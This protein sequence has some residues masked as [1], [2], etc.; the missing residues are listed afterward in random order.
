VFCTRCA[1]FN[2]PDTARCAGCGARL[3]WPTAARHHRR[4]S[5]PQSWFLLL[6]FALALAVI[7]L[8]GLRTWEARQ[9]Q[10][11][12]Y[13]RAIA[14]LNEGNLPA[15]IEQFGEAGGYR[16]AREQRITTQQLR[17]RTTPKPPSC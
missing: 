6:P 2:S 13:E 11:A 16:D 4:G 3:D 9:S 8:V 1:R 7:S 14:L 17:C 15:A 5:G 12:A 10:S